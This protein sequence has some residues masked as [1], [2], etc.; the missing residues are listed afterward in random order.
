MAAPAVP[1]FKAPEPPPHGV[2]R[3]EAQGQQPTGKASRA[4]RRPILFPP[5]PLEEVYVFQD[6]LDGLSLDD[7]GGW[8]HFDASGGPT[9]W[10]IDTFGACTNHGWW[11]GKIDS[12]WVSDQNRAG[13]GNN[14]Y[15][16]LE[17]NVSVAGLT[18]GTVVTLS[19]DY[20]IKTE[21]HYDYALI[22]VGDLS[23]IYLDLG[24]LT[25]T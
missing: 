14:W 1:S 15:Q 12:S 22:E 4:G 18:T 25:G 3:E 17:N 6:S 21:P 20:H 11:C 24:T 8:T 9:A 7:E 16:V 5:P 19:F 2:Y 13:Y 10:H 23:E